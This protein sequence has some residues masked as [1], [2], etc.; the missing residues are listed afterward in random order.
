MKSSFPGSVVQRR[1][2]IDSLFPPSSHENLHLSLSLSVCLSG[3]VNLVIGAIYNCT[4]KRT[5]ITIFSRRN[6][7]LV[8][9]FRGNFGPRDWF[10]GSRKFRHG[11]RNRR[12]IVETNSLEFFFFPSFFPSFVAF[13]YEEDR[14]R[15]YYRPLVVQ[16][17]RSPRGIAHRSKK[18]KPVNDLSKR[19]F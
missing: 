19:C 6:L 1:S 13:A 5:R 7:K 8:K 17:S 4:R 3:A 2:T 9:I 10:R 14:W 12:K 15:G 16:S 18:P 11:N